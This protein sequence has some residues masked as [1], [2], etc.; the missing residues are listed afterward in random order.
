MSKLRVALIEDHDL[1]RVGLRLVLQRH[2]TIEI[3]GEASDG[4]MGLKLLETSQPDVAVVD[5]GLPG[6][7]GIE[8]TRRFKQSLNAAATA[9]S[10]QPKVMIL[11]MQ[12]TE[13]S[14]LAAFAAGAD[15][16]C[17]KDLPA[18]RLLEALQSTY[19]GNNWIDPTIAQLV[20][21]H[22]RQLQSATPVGTS[23]SK[24]V[25]ILADGEQAPVLQAYP[26][27]QRELEIL[28][29]VVTGYTNAKIASECYITIGTVK[30]HIRNILNKLCVDDRTQAAVRAL[31]SGLV[32]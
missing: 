7:D 10:S 22:H 15:S 2:P 25:D 32:V 23:G 18:D 9:S 27:T 14:V 13:D 5:L 29:L 11:T 17:M 28:T 24:T 31:R 1:T 4:F 6:L 12:G 26:L 16:Y 3:V 19:E 30:T 20:L 8:V 21:Q